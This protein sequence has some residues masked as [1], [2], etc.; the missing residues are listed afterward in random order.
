MAVKSSVTGSTPQE[1]S[2]LVAAWSRSAPALERERLK[3]LERMTEGESARRFI[4]L[5]QGVPPYPQRPSSGLVEQ[6]RILARLR[7]P[8]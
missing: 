8:Q 1:A 6:Q 4:E 7:K 2:A 5:L 3:E